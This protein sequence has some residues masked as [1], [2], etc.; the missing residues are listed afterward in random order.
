MR[1]RYD[2]KSGYVN[3]SH[4]WYIL[5]VDTHLVSPRPERFNN[6]KMVALVLCKFL[7][8]GVCPN[9]L[10]KRSLERSLVALCV[11]RG[12]GVNVAGMHRMENTSK[13]FCKCLDGNKLR[14]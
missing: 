10:T 13:G 2:D 4:T 8:R 11:S 7:P 5:Q 12:Q 6:R 1:N 3:K 14:W 9:L